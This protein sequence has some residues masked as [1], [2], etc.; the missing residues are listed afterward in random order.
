MCLLGFLCILRQWQLERSLRN[1]LF[2]P[3][4]KQSANKQFDLSKLEVCCLLV[5]VLFHIEKQTH[6]W[7]HIFTLIVSPSLS[8]SVAHLLFLSFGWVVVC[9]QATL[10][11]TAAKQQQTLNV[12]YPFVCRRCIVVLLVDFNDVF[13]RFRFAACHAV[14]V[15]VRLVKKR[16]AKLFW[17]G[18]VFPG[19]SFERV[20]FLICSYPL[21]FPFAS[22]ILVGRSFGT[23]RCVFLNVICVILFGLGC[24]Y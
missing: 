24:V 17:R 22:R 7:L 2:C 3:S 8:L 23:R 13:L 11:Q 21:K 5:G 16:E 15:S 6:H 18:L 12:S 20:A 19:S 1:H 10:I 14:H 9:T 4:S